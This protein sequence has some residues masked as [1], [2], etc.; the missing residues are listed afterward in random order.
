[1]AV[2]S[3][4]TA[5]IPYVIRPP[6]RAPAE[7][8]AVVQVAKVG[9]DIYVLTHPALDRQIDRVSTAGTETVVRLGLSNPA[10]SHYPWL[11]ESDGFVV[12]GNT[13]WYGALA[14][15][16]SAAATTFIRSNGS[17]TTHVDPLKEASGWRLIV[18]P[19]ENPRA[20]EFSSTDE[21]TLV[22]ELEWTGALRSW[23]LPPA[24]RLWGYMAAERLPDGRI[25]LFSN[26]EGFRMYLLTGDGAVDSILLRPSHFRQF[27]TAMDDAGHIAIVA[28]DDDA[29]TVEGAIIDVSRPKE[30]QWRVLR[31]SARVTGNGREV[32]VVRITNGFVAAWINEGQERRIEATEFDERGD[33]GVVVNVGRASPR[34]RSAFFDLQSTRDELTFW[35]DDGEHLFRRQ[36]PAS[37]TGY[38]LVEALEGCFCATDGPYRN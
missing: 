35:W 9:D 4:G 38:A 33:R 20:L 26:R 31:R 2:V 17:R 3:F 30:A 10:G 7:P 16:D 21:L 22:R 1:M 36:L 6:I 18:L 13:W 27:G 5:E 37:L 15:S 34:E 14:E 25:A 28:A 12:A 23:R 8:V 32:Q 24:Y 11:R 19:G 29:R